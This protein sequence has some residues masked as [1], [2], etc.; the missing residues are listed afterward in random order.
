M[1]FAIC[2]TRAVPG[3]ATVFVFDLAR[4]LKRA[5]HDVHVLAGDG[6]WLV[7]K[8]ADVQIPFHRL[9][10]M[11]RELNPYKDTRALFELTSK[12]KE[13]KPD[14][15][16]L[17]SSKIGVLGSLAGKLAGIKNIVYCIGGWAFLEPMSKTKRAIIV[18]AER[19]AAK[20]RDAIVCVHPGDVEAAKREGIKP[21]Q[22]LLSIPNGV[23]VAVFDAQ[24]LT[25]ECAR[26]ILELRNSDFIFGSIANFYPAKD[27]PNFIL[28]TKRYRELGGTGVV[29]I[30]GDGP[31]RAETEKA[32]QDAGSDSYFML[33][34]GKEN[35]SQYLAA[36][37]A[38]ALP[39][40]KEGMPISLLEAMAASLSCI[41]TDVGAMR[42]MIEPDAGLIIEAH[43][44]ESLARA[45]LRLERDVDS[46]E[47]FGTQARRVV[48]D[49]FPLQKTLEAHEKLL[50]LPKQAI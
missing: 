45:M 33:L 25:R 7:E 1:K 14:A 49:R 23:D 47:A 6:E 20:F 3:G 34:G 31:L 5:G 19:I 39:S 44:P 32:I 43:N 24:L 42:W 26:E 38:Y 16:H 50:T 11:Q 35:A 21:K 17:N 10:W 13:L 2:I 29:A 40:A 8:C 22:Q 30:I 48:T 41:V 9:Q 28:A 18:F 12:L 15:I 46:R 27:L 36:F 4:F 37:D